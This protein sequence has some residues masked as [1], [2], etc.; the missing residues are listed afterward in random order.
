MSVTDN[1][2]TVDVV[3]SSFENPAIGNYYFNISGG[4]VQSGFDEE[5]EIISDDTTWT[6]R[7]SSGDYSIDDYNN[8]DYD[9]GCP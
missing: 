9:V 5:N 6:V 8:D 7:I 2:L 3:G 4:L 1:V